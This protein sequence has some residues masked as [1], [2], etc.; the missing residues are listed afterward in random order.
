GPTMFIS[1]VTETFYPDING[2]ATTLTQLHA[3]LLSAGHRV[4]VICP[5]ADESRVLDDGIEVP[6][7]A[8]PFYHSV[9]LGLP[10]S[11][12]LLKSWRQ[13]RPDLVHVATEGPLGFSALRMARRLGVPVTSSLHTNFHTYMTHYRVGWLANPV[14]RYLRWFHNRTALTFIP[15]DQQASELGGMGFERLTVLGRGVDTQL[16]NP[17]QRDSGLRNQWQQMA[18]GQ[19]VAE[20]LVALH[21]GRLAAEKNLDLLIAAFTAMRVARPDLVAVVVGDGPERARLERALPW[22]VFVGMKRGEALARHYASADFFVFPSKSETFGNVVLEAMASGL[23]C[24]SFNYAAGC[25][26]IQHGINGYLAACD[27]E[28][29]FIEIAEAISIQGV[30]SMGVRARH[31]AAAFDWGLITQTFEQHL[32]DVVATHATVVWTQPEAVHRAPGGLAS[33]GKPGG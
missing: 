12:R 6:G 22:V 2:V 30:G 28:A 14:M 31:T 29:G 33:R 1:L 18:G 3:A 32:R 27:D 19:R 26:L 15:T 16:F 9:R 5:R 7:F 21:V 20:P 24:I 17:D 11:G 23:A 4:Q 10:A 25:R 8:L 13:D